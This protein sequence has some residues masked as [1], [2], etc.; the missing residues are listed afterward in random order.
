MRKIVLFC[1]LVLPLTVISQ[2]KGQQVFLWENGAPGFENLR[3]E[4]EQAQDWWVRNIHNPSITVFLPPKDLANGAAVVICPGGGHINLVY[5]SEG[6]DA[7]LYFN[8]IGVA[9]FVLKYRL[10]RAP[11][12]KYTLQKHVREDAYRAMRLVRSRAEEW[13]VDTARVGIMGFSA[14]GEVAALIAYSPGKGNLQSSD[15]V[16][17]FNGKPD[18]QILVY[19]GPLGIPDKVPTDAPPVFMIAANDD[20]CCSGPVVKLIQ[21]YR[22]AKVSMEAHLYAQGDH[23]FNMGQRTTLKSI[24]NWPE[25]MHEWMA[26]TRLLKK[27]TTTK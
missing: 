27:E 22:E 23:A 24:K 4:K 6:R 19:P 14:G 15:T 9:A 16:E 3:N 1:F 21:A 18:F 26:D 13:G 25:R 2:N 7:A 12:S 17:H 8:S 5:D 20:V 11:D 10:S